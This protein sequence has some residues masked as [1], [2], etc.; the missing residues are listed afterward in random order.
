MSVRQWGPSLLQV[1]YAAMP[2][3]HGLGDLQVTLGII[4]ASGGVGCV[5]G[6][7]IANALIPDR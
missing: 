2:S 1:Q 3:M 4:M 7:L 6:P 5:L